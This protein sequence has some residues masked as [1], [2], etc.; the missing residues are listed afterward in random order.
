MDSPEVCCPLYLKQLK[1]RIFFALA[2]FIL[3]ARNHIW[4]AAAAPL[5]E[6]TAL[7]V[8]TESRP[9]L[10]AAAPSPSSLH[11]LSAVLMDGETGRILYEKNGDEVRPMASTT[12]IMTG[13]LALELGNPEQEIP[14]SKLAAVQP[15]VHLG[16][17]EG[18]T[19]RLEDLLYSLLLESHNDSAVA[20]AEALGGSVEGFAALMNE[21]AEAIGCHNTCFL[22]P[23]GLDETMETETGIK[24]HSTT[25][26]DLARIM[27]YC[28]MESPKREAFRTITKTSGYGFMANGRSFSCQN[29]NAFLQMMDGA[30][31]G[32]TGFT[33]EAGYCYVGALEREG[34]TFI[35]SLLACG[36]PNNKSY[37]WSDTKALMSYGLE[38][39]ENK[40]FPEPAEAF[41]CPVE[42]GIPESGDLSEQAQIR[43]TE[44]RPADFPEEILLGSHESITRRITAA[45]TL[46]APITLSQ[47]VGQVEYRIGD[48]VIA[49]AELHPETSV[50]ALTFSWCA[51]KTVD[52][53]LLH[54][55]PGS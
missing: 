52:L 23:N 15:K 51:E 27:R 41:F 32:K 21:K 34:R 36:W 26:K 45:K 5:Y 1:I 30:F 25:A 14:V 12:K 31:S 38:E 11:A 37:K 53:F 54:G 47:T 4:I 2:M 28:V 17:N 18:E 16:M 44:Q 43:I 42:G 50:E 9:V 19:Y 33:G 46:T 8:Q 49:E 7:S 24:I 39:F 13:I 20:V 6:K 29:H 22:T 3:S 40:T 48:Q 55:G 10:Q 35:V